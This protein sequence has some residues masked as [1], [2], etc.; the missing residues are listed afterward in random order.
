MN[1]QKSITIIV[2][3]SLL[4]AGMWGKQ[5][6]YASASSNVAQD[7]AAALGR[8]DPFADIPRKNVV[9]P[10]KLITSSQAPQ[11]PPDL[12]LE[13]VTLEFLDAK[14]AAAAFACMCSPAGN[15]TPLEKSNSLLVFDTKENM[16]KIVQHI[17]E[18]DQPHS[19]LF[20][21]AVTLKFL[22]AK[23]FENALKGMLSQYGSIATN[24][25][26]NSLII[27]D[28][29]GNL[30]RILA[31][32]RKADK[33]PQQIMVEVVILDVQLRDDTEI[34]INWDILSDELYDMSY[35]QNFTDRVSA[36]PGTP[37]TTADTARLNAGKTNVDLV[38]TGLGGDFSVISGTVRNVIHLIQQKRDVEILASPR[39]M[40]VSGQS[41]NIKAV[42]EI[43]YTE[44]TD[45]SQGGAGALT[46]TEFKEVGVNLQV[47][48]TVT[49][50]NDIFLTID[51][52]QNVKTSESL[53]G[54]PVVD[55]RRAQTALLL[56]DS[57][58]VVMGGL[59]RKEKTTQIDQIPVIGDLP[60]IG[61]LFKST[62]T[63][64]NNSELIV[65][66]S[67]HIYKGEPI[68]KD[69][70]A[71]YTEIRERPVLSVRDGMHKGENE[72]STQDTP[73]DD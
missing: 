34:G 6:R 33:T 3:M 12:F 63:V 43:P 15:I 24:E 60:I 32:I 17:R 2:C 13:V 55:T 4:A 64:V 48:A 67:P 16:D 61:G 42:E 29:K 47:S 51:T 72:S 41:A 7:I 22:D 26:S 20:V 28:T 53:G 68:P 70:M 62:N 56:K 45:T 39:A 38:S 65:L 21:D 52:E 37:Q 36:T 57:Q 11:N 66:L 8:D 27:C 69:V 54:V 40:M 49:D 44:V 25:T 5:G 58:I 10:A 31:E 35:R 23:N 18:T 73:K 30:Q 50:G 19:G 14:S 9:Q 59:R 71:K 1:K 46:S